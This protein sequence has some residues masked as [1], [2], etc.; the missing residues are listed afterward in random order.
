[1][2][3][4]VGVFVLFAETDLCTTDRV[5]DLCTTSMDIKSITGCQYEGERKNG[6]MEGKGKYTFQD[7]Q[8]FE[9]DFKDGM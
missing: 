9:G 8:W 6:R 2:A 1:M 7:D 4:G 5:A 3:L